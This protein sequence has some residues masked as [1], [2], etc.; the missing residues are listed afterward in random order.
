MERWRASRKIA[1]ERSECGFQLAA[2]EH[3]LV[4]SKP[5]GDSVPYDFIVDCGPYQRKRS[6]LSRVQVRASNVRN[7]KGTYAIKLTLGDGRRRLTT[8]HADFLAAHI[9]PC[10]AWYIIPLRALRGAKWVIGLRPQSTK[11]RWERYREA[12]HL[13]GGYQLPHE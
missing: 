7:K 10:N 12:W 5:F 6:R 9:P 11:S 3:M 1:G 13:L 4:V 2:L 8:A